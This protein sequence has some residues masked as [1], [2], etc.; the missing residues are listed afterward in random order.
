MAVPSDSTAA[1]EW[2]LS[3][4]GVRVLRYVDLAPG[5]AMANMIKTFELFLPEFTMGVPQ[6]VAEM[7]IDFM[8]KYTHFEI[9]PRDPSLNDP[10]PAREVHSGDSFYVMRL[11]GLNPLLGW[12]MGSTTGHV[13]TALWIDDELY[14]C[15]STIDDSYWPT[16]HVQ[17]TPYEMWLKQA[18]DAD[19][20]VVW[21][22]LND[23]AKDMYNETAAIQ[24]FNSQEGFD[25]GFKTLIWGWLDTAKDNFP[26]LPPN[27]D[28]CLQWELL[29]PLLAIVDR[30]VPEI[31]DMIWNPGYNKRLGTEG[32]RTAEMYQEAA[33][34]GMKSVDVISI[35]EQDT[36]TY[37]TTRYDEPAEGRCMVCC[38]F[39]C[40][41]WK[42]AGVFGDLAD[43]INCAEQ[44]NWDDYALTIHADT[45]R[46][47]VG[48]YSLELNSFKTKDLYAHMAESCPS[49]A[50]EYDKPSD[51]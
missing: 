10:P 42:A 21:V 32:L 7:N 45:Y 40:S 27:F 19:F 51:C 48:T 4:K 31:G 47:I 23:A 12:A 3:T 6:K 13:T 37:N 16:D 30:N 29:E 50:P 18:R 44:T 25:Y 8:S 9:T 1:E 22:P 26:C 28:V 36:W 14:V 35:P 43:S 33:R 41:M 11:D 49:L 24:W 17:K 5:E 15:E 38:V 2:D 34:Q 46:Q 20:Q 39:V